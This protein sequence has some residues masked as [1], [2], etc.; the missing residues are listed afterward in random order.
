[1]EI[2]VQCETREPEHCPGCD[3]QFSRCM[4]CQGTDNANDLH[5]KW[6][7]AHYYGTADEA[8]D[9]YRRVLESPR[10]QQR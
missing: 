9:A 3:E 6:L 8:V 4:D 1:M 10:W 5:Y 7:R 2:C